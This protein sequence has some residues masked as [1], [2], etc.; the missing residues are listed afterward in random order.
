M[1]FDRY[2][3]DD[4]KTPSS[5]PDFFGEEELVPEQTPRER[6]SFVLHSSAVE[7]T[8]PRRE[9]GC[10]KPLC[11][12]VAGIYAVLDGVS[13]EGFEHV[14]C[15]HAARVLLYWLKSTREREGLIPS[16]SGDPR[17]EARRLEMALSRTHSELKSLGRKI[18]PGSGATIGC[19]AV[20]VVPAGTHLVVA[21][22][23]DARL[24][25][26]RAGVVT[27]LTVDHTFSTIRRLIGGQDDT[28]VRRSRLNTVPSSHL[29]ADGAVEPEINAVELRDGDHYL[30]CNA[31][32]ACALRSDQM[33]T[34]LGEVATPASVAEKLL[35]AASYVV[36][37][38][39]FSAI[40]LHTEAR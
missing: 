10:S 32:L 7:R 23:G 30:L 20:A 27:Q 19:S 1:L 18:V 39:D 31:A 36:P 9:R 38:G 17:R 16:G 28:T 12:D 8:N 4:E 22:L 33:R 2:F 37:N 13:S 25:R 11:D 5:D 3:D 35:T 24:Y 14:S 15:V 34:R 29:G 6:R 26:S 40:V 21:W